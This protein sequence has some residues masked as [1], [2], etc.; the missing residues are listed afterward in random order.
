MALESGAF[1][2]EDLIDQLM[3]F[4]AAGH[5]TTATAMTWAAYLLARHPGAQARLRREVR[6]HLPSPGGLPPSPRDAAGAEIPVTSADV[7]RLPYLN[8]VCSEVLRYFAPVPLTL[9]EAGPGAAIQ[10]RAIPAGT[11]IVLAPWATNFDPALWGADAAEFRPERWLQRRRQ[12]R[13]RQQEKGA[14]AGTDDNDHDHDHHGHDHD[15]DHDHHGEDDD[16]SSS[17][18]SSSG[19]GGGSTRFDAS[20]GASS[21][22]ANLTFLHGPRSCIGQ[23]FAKAEF[24]CLL[25]CWVGRFEFALRDERE[26]DERNISIKS[27]GPTARPEHGMHLRTTVV[28]GW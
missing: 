22:F 4:L 14:D 10:G 2:D 13:P 7:D 9:R 28:D 24:A 20:G 17:S 8:A 26:R 12:E 5:E 25:A 18:S 6:A 23:S 27:S 11:A 1:G 16:S 3:T 19:G 15:H 21:N